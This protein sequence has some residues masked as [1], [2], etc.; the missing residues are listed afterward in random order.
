MLTDDARA[1]LAAFRAATDAQWKRIAATMTGLQL[2]SAGESGSQV[3]LVIS[4]A[5]FYEGVVIAQLPHVVIER[6]GSRRNPT[7][8]EA[9]NERKPFDKRQIML[10]DAEI[11][12]ILARW[13][14]GRSAIGLPG[15][16]QVQDANGRIVFE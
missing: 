1:G 13:R 9:P 3:M 14:D 7:R 4:R 2:I 16:P 15:V 12:A 6:V 8:R 5:D 10:T 11:D